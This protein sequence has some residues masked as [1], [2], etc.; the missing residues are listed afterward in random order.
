M[1]TQT[2]N[3]LEWLQPLLLIVIMGILLLL[4]LRQTMMLS[5]AGEAYPKVQRV[6]TLV[7]CGDKVEA[8]PFK[9]GDYVGR[10][11]GDC[12]EGRQARIVGIYS[13][14]VALEKPR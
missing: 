7:A 11:L 5:R 6:V 12:G 10:V 2:T 3:P 13:E 14:E 1:V 8:R 4:L 9:E